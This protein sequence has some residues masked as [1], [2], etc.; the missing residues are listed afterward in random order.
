MDNP[1]I[2]SLSA[3]IARFGEALPPIDQRRHLWREVAGH[4]PGDTLREFRAFLDANA[5]HIH[6][7]LLGEIGRI[8]NDEAM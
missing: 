5:N 2:D 3:L 8:L 7:T 4:N 1:L 6:P